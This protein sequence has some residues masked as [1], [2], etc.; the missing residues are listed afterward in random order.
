MGKSL[1]DLAL[2]HEYH[3]KL[4]TIFARKAKERWTIKS[5][6]SQI[7]IQIL[8]VDEVNNKLNIV[9]ISIAFILDQNKPLH[10]PKSK[11]FTY[12]LVQ[13]KVI[14]GFRPIFSLKL[15][16]YRSYDIKVE[17]KVCFYKCF[18][19][20]LGFC[21]TPIPVLPRKSTVHYYFLDALLGQTKP[22]CLPKLWYKSR[23]EGL[24]L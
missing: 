5:Q 23:S 13:F 1:K 19:K 4:A 21:C 24:L 12:N 15:Y 22:L 18:T 2:Y 17:S 7:W 9:R 6:P 14:L 11:Y 3:H 10:L 20:I 8:N 16:V